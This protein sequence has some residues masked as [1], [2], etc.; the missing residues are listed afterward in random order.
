MK[1]LSVMIKPA[2]AKCNASCKYCFYRDE[3]EARKI[4][5]YGCTSLSLADTL[6][7]KMLDYVEGGH[8]SIVFQ[9]GEPTLAGYSFFEHFF[10]SLNTKNISGAKISLSLQTNGLL[11]DKQWAKLFKKHNVLV[12]LSL[13]GDKKACYARVAHGKEMF[14]SILECAS[15][16]KKEGVDFC[17]LSVIHKGNALRAKEIYTDLT[18]RGFR[19]LQFI[20]YLGDNPD[21]ILSSEDYAKFL[22][23][24]YAYYARDFHS[25]TPTRIRQFDNYLMLLRLGHAEQCGMNG[26]CEESL[27]FEGDGTAFPCDFYCTD[28][29]ALGNINESSIAELLASPVATSFRSESYLSEDCQTCP[30]FTICRG[31]CKRYMQD[32]AFCEAYKIFFAHSFK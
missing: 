31:G 1:N 17:I 4:K 28:D 23:D 21:F 24:T 8:L 16:L 13:D 25:Q 15:I 27:T 19:N 22:I 12:G 3:V 5:D 20:P 7:D 30:Y 2:S 9:G 11:I 6:I 18:R 32:K 14:A 26:R 29:Y 10:Q